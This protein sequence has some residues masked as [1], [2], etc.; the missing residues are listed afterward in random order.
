MIWCRISKVSREN[1]KNGGGTN[2]ISK[3][4]FLNTNKNLYINE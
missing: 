2:G 4:Y 3:K 1:K